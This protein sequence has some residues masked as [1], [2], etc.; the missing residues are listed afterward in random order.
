MASWLARS[1][2]ERALRVQALAGDIVLCSWARHFTLT[3]PLSTQVYKW[4]YG[5]FNAGGNPAMDWHPIQGG[6]EILPVTPC[7]RNRDKL[8]PDGPLGPNAD[9]TYS[10]QYLTLQCI[11]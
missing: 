2:P 1:T 8:R 4:V 6:V 11:Y 3:V 10:V 5:R 7:Y 9:F